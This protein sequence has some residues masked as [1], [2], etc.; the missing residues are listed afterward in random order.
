[1]IFGS[2]AKKL[3]LLSKAQLG[4]TPKNDET[5]LLTASFTS[6]K[7]END[8]TARVELLIQSGTTCQDGRRSAYDFDEL[9]AHVDEP[10][11]SQSMGMLPIPL[12]CIELAFTKDVDD[13]NDKTNDEGSQGTFGS[14]RFRWNSIRSP[15][16]ST[17]IVDQEN[18]VEPFF[19]CGSPSTTMPM[20]TDT[21]HNSMEGY[22][23]SDDTSLLHGQTVQKT[24]KFFKRSLLDRPVEYRSSA[25]TSTKKSSRSTK[26]DGDE[27]YESLI[28]DPND[29]CNDW[30]HKQLAFDLEYIESI[31]VAIRNVDHH[32]ANNDDEPQCT[33]HPDDIALEVPPPPSTS[34]PVRSKKARK[35]GRV[36]AEEQFKK[37]VDCY[38]SPSFLDQLLQHHTVVSDSSIPDTF[39]VQDK[40]W[41]NFDAEMRIGNGN[42]RNMK[43]YR[44]ISP[45][46]CN[47]F[48]R[49]NGMPVIRE[50]SR[51]SRH[52]RH[53]RRR[54]GRR[55]PPILLGRQ[56]ASNLSTVTERPS[57]EEANS[58]C[59]PTPMSN[60]N[61]HFFSTYE[62]DHSSS[63]SEEGTAETCSSKDSST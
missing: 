7:E 56:F 45:V 25:S 33:L 4:L 24:F 54:S 41:Q 26:E 35:K 28:A 57:E 60:K 32:N 8:D 20:M 16:S 46:V 62:S 6:D 49:C 58:S 38:E 21:K 18:F 47:R 5:C 17:K 48:S 50:V 19:S 31:D 12:P 36:I 14:V 42:S 3:P 23:C 53:G 61:R 15:F 22:D 52:S 34:P 30:I 39:D 51:R 40:S 10:I 59:I 37:L 11:F 13:T 27:Q 63:R 44:K 2:A 29:M 43:N 55:S 1:M 9:K